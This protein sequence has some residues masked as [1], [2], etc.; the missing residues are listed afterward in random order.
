VI[1]GPYKHYTLLLSFY[2]VVG[3]MLVAAHNFGEDC[4]DQ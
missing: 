2:I 1:F 3:T 4:T